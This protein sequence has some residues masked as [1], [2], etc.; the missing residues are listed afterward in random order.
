MPCEIGAPIAS[1][2]HR[3][4]K[5]NK[6]VRVVFTHCDS[7]SAGYQWRSCSEWGGRSESMAKYTRSDYPVAAA[8]ERLESS[9]ICLSES[10]RLCSRSTS[11]GDEPMPATPAFHSVKEKHYHNNT[12]C[13]PGSE[14]P[15]HNRV[16]GTGGLKLCADCAKL[17]GEGK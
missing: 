13:G 15:P 12:K 14:I 5:S 10:A 6:C 4:I 9:N 11:T 7:S 8:E 1:V 16:L 17:N 2:M 3:W